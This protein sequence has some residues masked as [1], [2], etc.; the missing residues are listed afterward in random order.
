MKKVLVSILFLILSLSAQNKKVYYAYIEGDIDLGLAPYVKRVVSEAEKNLADAVIFKINTFGG[1]V[2]AATQI[3]DAILNSKVKTIAFIDKRAISAGA[4]ISIACDSIFMQPGS[5]IGAAT[6]VNQA[7]EQVPDKYQSYMRKKMRATAEESGRNPD[8]A[9]AMVYPD[10]VVKGISDSGK[11]VTFTTKE[12][13]KHGFCEA[14]LEDLNEV[15]NRQQIK[16]YEVIKQKLT[17]QDKILDLLTS[18][19][20]SGILIMIIIGGIYFELQTPGLGFPII[21]AITA[22]TLYFAPHYLNGLSENWE[23]LLF[24]IGIVLILLEV[25]VIPGF[26]VAGIS[27]IICTVLGLAFS[28]VGNVGFDFSF[29]PNDALV[30]SVALVLFAFFL[31]LSSSIFVGYK[32]LNSTLFSHLILSKTQN[33]AEGYISPNSKEHEVIGKTGITTTVLRPSGKIEIEDNTY[34]ATAET[35]FI[36]KGTEVVVTKFETS[37]LTV[38]VV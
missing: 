15:M 14:E 11:V 5:T 9:E 19:S 38:R 22:A 2:D 4:L 29:V 21:A 36:E 24:G 3:K 30:K 26:G 23:I 27:G 34:D 28:L 31:S 32:F 6:V 1:R 13:I 7:G 37:Q 16:D 33:K 12:A 8:I 25:F 20:V 35:G 17:W 18:S 10:K